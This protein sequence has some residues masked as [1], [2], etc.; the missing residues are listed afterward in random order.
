MGMSSIHF[1]NV[2]PTSQSHNLRLREFDYVRQDLAHLNK[3]FG[4]KQSH[5]EIIS[6]LK[7]IV[8][9]K[10]KRAPQGKAKFILEGVFLIEEKHTND[11]L[12]K[13][14][15]DFKRKFKIKL[16][17]LH[18]HRDEGHYDEKNV[19]KP[20]LHAHL[21]IENIDR[22]TGKSH[23]W[24][25]EDLSNIQTFFAEALQM[26]RGKSSEK[27]HL[28]SLEHK[29]KAKEEQLKLLEEKALLREKE[30]LKALNHKIKAKEEQLK[31]LEENAPD[32]ENLLSR[33]QTVLSKERN[34]ISGK[35]SSDFAMKTPVEF[36]KFMKTHPYNARLDELTA[37][38]KNQKII[39]E[40]L[41]RESENNLKKGLK[42][43]L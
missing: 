43:G 16:I 3:S 14:V 19:W 5:S 31:I 25:K 26:E 29:I 42:K 15:N 21:L 33:E 20:N 39:S 30:L 9:E 37:V 32:I 7:E 36:A 28:N 18:I 27:K 13:V 38:I 41:K 35:I 10:T 11:D 12:R 6:E 2:K 34:L 1:E 17:G 8:K 22:E 24:N 40:K 23:R 4:D